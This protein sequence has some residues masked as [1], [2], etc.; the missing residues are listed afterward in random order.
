MNKKIFGL[1][2]SGSIQHLRFKEAP[3]DRH[4]QEGQ[5]INP[6]CQLNVSRNTEVR[7]QWYVFSCT[8]YSRK[9]QNY[10]NPN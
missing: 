2:A 4:I 6:D 7:Y 3:I 5:S 9:K 10:Q 1:Q 8:K